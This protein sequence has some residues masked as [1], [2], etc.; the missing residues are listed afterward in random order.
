VKPKWPCGEKATSKEGRAPLREEVWSAK[1][2]FRWQLYFGAPTQQTKGGMALNK[3]RLRKN[4]CR[5][6]KKTERKR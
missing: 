2:S 4:I 6:N 1:N 3:G 5:E